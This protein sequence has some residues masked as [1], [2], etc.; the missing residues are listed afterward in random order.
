[1][2]ANTTFDYEF[3]IVGT[4]FGGL[5]AALKLQELGKTS[6][7][8]FERASEIGGTW[9]DNVYP[10][11]A[12]DI[13]SVLYSIASQPNPAW[14]RTF[15][16]QPEIWAYMKNVVQRNNLVPHIRF[17]TSVAEAQFL[18]NEG[19]W[20][21]SDQHG[22]TTRVRMLLLATGPL[23]RPN[24]PQFAGMEQF[25]GE[26]LHSAEWRVDT[27]LKGKRV[28]VIGTGASAI[29]IVPAIAP[30]VQHLCVFQRTP[31]W[32]LPRN[33]RAISPSRKA[34][35][36][37]FPALQRFR[38]NM[39][40]QGNEVGGIPFTRE[41]FLRNVVEW[42]ALQ[43]LK[44]QVQNPETQRKLTP[45][46]RLG[47][48]RA[49]VSDDFYPTF[50]QSHVHLETAP[51]L[52][53]MENGLRLENGAE[54]EFDVIVLATGFHAADGD[55]DVQIRG[56]QGRN[57]VEGWKETGAEAYLGTTVAGFPN[58]ALVLGP[59][60]GGGHNSVLD[61]MESQMRY[62]AQ[63]I[64]HLDNQQPRAFLDVRAD[65]QRAYNEQLQ[66]MFAGTV[67]A[68]GC[69][70]WYINAQGRN[71]TIYPRVNTHFRKATGEWK[72]HEYMIY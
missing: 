53:F 39:I 5:I 45:A 49:L 56:L 2:S 42:Y 31:A 67:W 36:Q 62:I 12:C 4:G 24:K 20:L 6:F 17:N 9:R 57:L 7:V 3:G 29:Q 47:C 32:V 72:P 63:Y 21:V 34:L 55:W 11:C 22:A 37:R 44:R 41:T 48:K 59:N 30:L 35:Y 58:L 64:K 28:A 68:S 18:E 25:R 33:D 10:G 40:F 1:M 60:T 14:S 16:T 65:V 19:V 51:I 27:D 26:I 23:N 38:R 50:N 52:A 8:M 13:A 15:S 69:Q 70:S 66:A 43:H 71:T 54:S 61:T 46:Y